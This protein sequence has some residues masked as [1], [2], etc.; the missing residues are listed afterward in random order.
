MNNQLG[1]LG[2]EFFYAN[3]STGYQIEKLKRNSD[4]QLV[5]KI[6]A[7]TSD[8]RDY[9]IFASDWQKVEAEHSVRMVKTVSIFLRDFDEAEFEGDIVFA[10]YLKGTCRNEYIHPPN[11]FQ[12]IDQECALWQLIGGKKDLRAVEVNP[13]TAINPEI[14]RIDLQPSLMSSPDFF[15]NQVFCG[16]NFINQNSSWKLY[17]NRL[18]LPKK[19]YYWSQSML[20]SNGSMNSVQEYLTKS[21][22]TPLVISEKAQL[23]DVAVLFVDDREKGGYQQKSTVVKFPD[24]TTW[25]HAQNSDEVLQP[26]GAVVLTW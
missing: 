15:V 5:Q 26:K 1:K 2:V 17:P 21:W 16:A 18:W 20:A 7:L 11:R 10:P 9:V 19:A 8:G 24:R 22:Q 13:G 23:R 4:T 25:L 3:P 12:R 14:Q 6:K